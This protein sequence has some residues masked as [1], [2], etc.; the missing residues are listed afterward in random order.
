MI[1]SHYVTLLRI[2]GFNYEGRTTEPTPHCCTIFKA[3]YPAAQA[4]HPEYPSSA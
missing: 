2:A 1:R 3:Y 4:D